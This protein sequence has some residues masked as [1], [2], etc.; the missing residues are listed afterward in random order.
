MNRNMEKE[1]ESRGE[2]EAQRA[3][4]EA[5]ESSEPSEA[6]SQQA[7]VEA[8]EVVSQQAPVEASEVES[9]QEPAEASEAKAQKEPV[10]ASEVESQQVPVEATEAES[11]QESIEASAVESQQNSHYLTIPYLPDDIAERFE[12]GDFVGG[13]YRNLLSA[14][15]QLSLL[16]KK[17]DAI[18]IGNENVSITATKDGMITRVRLDLDDHD[19]CAEG[20]CSYLGTSDAHYILYNNGYVEGNGSEDGKWR[21]FTN[22]EKVIIPGLWPTPAA[23]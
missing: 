17:G 4:E 11:P 9:Q 20:M 19:F 14:T 16:K 15:D 21:V 6:E 7:P 22:E 13:D 5:A 18:T 10:E 23:V 8:S 1:E 2:P 12:L 3:S